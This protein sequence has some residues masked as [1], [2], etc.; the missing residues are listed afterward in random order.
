MLLKGNEFN[1][2]AQKAKKEGWGIG[3]FFMYDY[4]CCEAI[5]SAAE[6]MNTPI[7]ALIAD[8]HDPEIQE[9]NPLSLKDTENFLSV[10]RNRIERATV[11]IAY[12]LDHCTTLGGCARAIQHGATSVMIDASMKSL[13]E[14]IAITQRV[15]E[16]CRATNVMLEAE[17]GHVTGHANST[18]AVYTDVESAK[19]FY[20]E[21][22]VELLAVSIGTVHGVYKSEP[23]L[24]YDR[25]AELNEAIPASLVMHGGSGL[26]PEQFANCVE[27]GIVK[28]NVATYMQLAGGQAIYDA[29]QKA[30]AGK[31]THYELAAAGRK[32]MVNWT[33]EH[34]G[35]F[36]TKTVD[37]L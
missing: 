30:Q 12:H 36:K 11:P 7:M 6:E 1:A 10:C 18:G 8:F 37:Q 22:G 23:V 5:I 14:N 2:I 27:R 29:V 28:I 35:Y 32:A 9:G 16:I 4:E 3:A 26:T 17:I 31:V 34:I 19:K 24:N 13:E 20:D 21:T 25:I 15:K 33:K